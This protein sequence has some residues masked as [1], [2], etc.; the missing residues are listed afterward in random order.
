MGKLF[1]C[2]TPIGNLEDVSIRLLKTLRQVDIIACEDTRHTLKLLNRYK[3]K[4]KLVSYH[5]HSDKS[6]EDYLLRELENGKNIAVVSDAGMPSISDPGQKLVQKAIEEDISIEII[7]GPSALTTAL[8]VSG[9]DSTSFIFAGFL[10]NRRNRRKEVLQQLAREKRTVIFYEAPHRLVDTLVDM[11]EILGPERQVV[12][13]R[14]LTK[15]HEEIIRNRLEMVKNHF[16]E[17]SP[18]GEIC[19]LVAGKTEEIDASPDLDR[20]AREVDQLIARGY[21]KKEAFKMKASEYHISKST[22]YNHYVD[23][24]RDM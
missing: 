4:N 12:V 8:A 23:K 2:A 22:I 10:P 9:L 14:E 11:E 20:I 18:R 5:Q 13:A 15:T 3:I 7:P 16:I 17:H 24:F 6:K 19:I 1:L 21:E